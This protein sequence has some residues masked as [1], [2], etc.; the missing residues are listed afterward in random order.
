M[1]NEYKIFS[2][3]IPNNLHEKIA[4]LASLDKRS[5]NT[6]MINVLEQHVNSDECQK[7]LQ[8]ELKN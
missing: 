4:K 8:P 1:S 2:F 7:L 5:I 6:Y 3:R